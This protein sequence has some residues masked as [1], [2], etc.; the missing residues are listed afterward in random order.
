MEKDLQPMVTAAATLAAIQSFDRYSG[1]MFAIPSASIGLPYFPSNYMSM[2]SPGPLF[3]TMPSPGP[4]SMMPSPGPLSVMPSPGPLSVMPS[5]GPILMFSSPL[6]VSHFKSGTS[7]SLSMA[8]SPFYHLSPI[9]PN[10]ASG[11]YSPW[12]SFVA[13]ANVDE[14]DE[15]D[16]PFN[17]GGTI[18]FSQHTTF[19]QKSA[20]MNNELKNES[21]GVQHSDTTSES[22]SPT[23]DS[24]SDAPAN[25]TD[26]ARK[27][28]ERARKIMEKKFCADVKTRN[29][30]LAKAA[31]RRRNRRVL[32]VVAFNKRRG[33]LASRTRKLA[34]MAQMGNQRSSK[35]RKTTSKVR[36]PLK[37]LTDLYVLKFRDNFVFQ[38]WSASAHLKISSRRY[39]KLNPRFKSAPSKTGTRSIAQLRSSK[40]PA[41]LGVFAYDCGLTG[42][43]EILIALRATL[44]ALR[45][46]SVDGFR[47]TVLVVDVL[48]CAGRLVTI[49]V[50]MI[51]LEVNSVRSCGVFVYS[52]F[53]RD[54]QHLVRLCAHLFA[55][56]DSAEEKKKKKKK[57]AKTGFTRPWTCMAAFKTKADFIAGVNAVL[58]SNI[59]GTVLSML[60]P[61]DTSTLV[62]EFVGNPDGFPL[63]FARDDGGM[64]IP[65]FS[66][67]TQ[68]HVARTKNLSIPLFG[69]IVSDGDGNSVCGSRGNSGPAK[70]K[71]RGQK[72]CSHSAVMG[73]LEAIAKTPGMTQSKLFQNIVALLPSL[74]AVNSDFSQLAELYSTVVAWVASADVDVVEFVYGR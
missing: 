70:P 39:F 18:G 47:V 29:R 63:T 11:F 69:S 44:P 6:H 73:S 49:I 12:H 57:K 68:A 24:A 50:P 45:V 22:D 40:Y 3:M 1:P 26:R 25:E 67:A 61:L 66:G 53:H 51:G 21:D 35:K 54:L 60:G 5:P 56:L 31:T 74:F 58:L 72:S 46:V 13:P 41:K 33:R 43:S 64:T 30:R 15:R 19:S 34:K 32:Q 8:Q 4:L 20:F 42:P 62:P 71:G 36:Q 27:K 65:G 52:H 59:S 38:I 2:P 14:I 7:A 55:L 10:L 48:M 9:L 28:R 16:D 17:C 23:L 37:P